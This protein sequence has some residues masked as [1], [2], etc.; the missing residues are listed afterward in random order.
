MLTVEQAIPKAT[1]LSPSR[2]LMATIPV[3]AWQ[4]LVID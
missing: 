1:R 2:C 4:R 3:P